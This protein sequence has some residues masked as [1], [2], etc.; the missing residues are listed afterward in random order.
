MTEYAIVNNGSILSTFDADISGG[1]IRLL[2]SPT[3]AVTT[4]KIACSAIRI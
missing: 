2:A 4:Y 3:N 1:N